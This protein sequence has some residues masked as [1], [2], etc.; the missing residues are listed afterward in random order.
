MGCLKLWTSEAR[1]YQ[2]VT[3]FIGT[4]F[5]HNVVKMSVIQPSS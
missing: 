5:Y 2:N 1:A 4:D 3:S